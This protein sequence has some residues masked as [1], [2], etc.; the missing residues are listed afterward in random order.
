MER[1]TQFV[2]L[3]MWNKP[4]ENPIDR[5]LVEFNKSILNFMC[6]DKVLRIAK[7]I[8][9]KEKQSLESHST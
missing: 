8:L 2:N 5:F 6:K 1:Y 9:N 7:T 3:K 4:N